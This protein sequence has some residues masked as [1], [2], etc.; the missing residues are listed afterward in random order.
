MELAKTG[1]GIGFYVVSLVVSGLLFFGW[2]RLFR[3]VFRAEY[4]VVLATAMAA[5]IT[6]PVVLLVL[7]WLLALLKK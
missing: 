2:R 5:I 7:L 4:W 6:T 1:F 3:R